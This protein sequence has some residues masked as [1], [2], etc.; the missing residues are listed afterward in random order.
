MSGS[1]RL[2]GFGAALDATEEMATDMHQTAHLQTNNGVTE[3]MRV[4]TGRAR[5][6]TLNTVGSP[7][8][9]DPNNPDKT[10][11]R[12]QSEGEAVSRR[13]ELGDDS[14]VTNNVGYV[15]FLEAKD[16]MFEVTVEEVV[17][18]FS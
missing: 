10:G 14:F 1:V 15:E 12:V 13:I 11:A 7:G 18:Q 3:K 5:G 8:A 16:H 2:I 4:D 17:G 9:G 6:G